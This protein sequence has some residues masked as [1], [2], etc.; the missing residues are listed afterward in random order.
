M[1]PAPPGVSG[2]RLLRHPLRCFRPRCGCPPTSQ[3][4]P[5]SGRT[6]APNEEQPAIAAPTPNNSEPRINDRI[7]AREVR[8]VGPDGAQIGIK[9][10]PEALIFARELD[11][12][13]VE[14]ADKANPPVCRVMDYGKYKYET[15]QKAKESRRKSTNVVIKEMKYRPK[16]GGGDFETKTK[17]VERFLAEGHKVKVTIMFRGREVAH[18][19]LGKKILDRVAEEII[20]TGRV[21]VYPKLDGPRNMIMVLAPDK[22]AQ[23][24]H[25]A[26]LKKAAEEAAAAGTPIDEAPEPTALVD[27]AAPEATEPVAEAEPEATDE[28]VEPEAEDSTEPDASEPDTEPEA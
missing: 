18:P 11:L 24:A 19:E 10:L 6:Y 8:L 23:A 14:V 27:E 13:L 5:A 22:K 4:A 25:A 21:E 16:I 26:E 3:N 1:L 15:A 7:R 28:V 2:C 12:D 9:P 17:K 20:N